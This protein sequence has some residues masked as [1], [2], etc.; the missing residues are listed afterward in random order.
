MK[1]FLKKKGEPLFHIVKRTDMP[2]WK[3]W[4]LRGVALVIAFLLSGIVC[5]ILTKG[6][7]FG[8]FYYEMFNGTFGSGTRVR[9]MFQS[10]AILMCISLAVTPAFKMK[11]WNIG[12]EG[13]TLMGA[14]A[15]AIMIWY[16]GGKVPEGVLIIMML[17]ASLVA[18]AIWALIPA[19]FKAIW[20]TN[21]TLFTLMMNYIATQLIL[22]VV[23]S[24]L[25]GPDGR[26]LSQSIGIL[27]HG[28]FADVMGVLY[29]INIVIVTVVTGIVF[30]YLQFSKHGYELEV[31]GESVNTAKYVG[32]NVKKVIIR[33]M[34]FSGV[35][36]GLAGFLLV[37]GSPTPTLTPNLA[38]GNG[39]TAILVAWLA[40]FNPLIMVGVALLVVF[41][42]KGAAQVGSALNISG[43]VA[44]ASV[45][46]GMFFLLVIAS[47]FLVNYKVIFR[48]KAEKEKKGN[49]NASTSKG[50]RDE[51]PATEKEEKAE[52]NG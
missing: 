31:V 33:T 9:N 52:V 15:S 22:F 24:W 4:L 46:V 37:G 7:D 51:I 48:G 36:C 1:T 38:A 27:P 20:N 12:A 25:M 42:Q 19:I 45:I 41:M 5:L 3:A 35:L 29:L 17:A 44:F 23:N 34:A 40:Q 47:E 10:W 28:S 6:E 43:S 14:L 18:G 8:T 21:E 11:F 16:F 26:M 13:Q 49:V 39:F 32:I 2:S 30:V 50:V